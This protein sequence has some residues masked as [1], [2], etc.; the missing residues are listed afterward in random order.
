[1]NSYHTSREKRAPTTTERAPANMAVGTVT[2]SVSDSPLHCQRRAPD[3]V[4][5][6]PLRE[7]AG[8]PVCVWGGGGGGGYDSTA[9]F[10]CK[11]NRLRITQYKPDCVSN[12]YEL[13]WKLYPHVRV[14]QLQFMRKLTICNRP[15]Y[16]TRWN[17]LTV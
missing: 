12:Y 14:F 16:L 9:G 10:E 1:M 15:F 5:R 3:V 17:V 8:C 13:H 11:V 7:W 2:F 6:P 4:P